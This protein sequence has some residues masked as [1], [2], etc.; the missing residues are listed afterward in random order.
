M[1]FIDKKNLVVVF[2]AIP[3]EDLNGKQAALGEEIGACAKSSKLF[4]FY[5][6]I[7][8]SMLQ[9]KLKDENAAILMILPDEK[10]TDY[11]V[12]LYAFKQSVIRSFRDAGIVIDNNDILFDF[13]SNQYIEELIDN[14]KRKAQ[15]S[16]A[17]QKANI[18]QKEID[19]YDYEE[20]A[21][22]FTPVNPLYSFNRVILPQDVI[23]KIERAVA[24][25]ENENKV[26][27]EWGLYEIQPH[28]SM[29][30][31]FFGPSGTGK[32]MAAEAVAEKLGKKILKVSYADVESKYHGEGPKMVKAI[33]L[34]AEKSGA[35]LFF[36]EA[37]SLLSK[38]LTNVS[39]GSEQ[40]INSMRSQL[41][42]CLE[43]FKGIV[44]F[45]TNLVIN[46]DKAFLTRLVSVAFPIPDE[47]TRI[48][49]WNNHIR[50]VDD[51]K[52][53]MLNIP[54]AP[55]VDTGE[56]A[57]KYEFVGREIRNAVVNACVNAA[58]AGKDMVSQADFMQACD[59]I[60]KEKDSI[61]NGKNLEMRKDSEKD[62]IRT[63]ILN[64]MK[65]EV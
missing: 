6:S 65:E 2:N 62:M 26:F 47:A 11:G 60:V 7:T 19:E 41:L 48:K 55:D 29:A 43:E 3:L 34:A 42:I 50:P 52:E 24:V 14:E 8:V 61:K 44:I 21:K 18:P 56:L 28:P 40:A 64:K 25:L 36:D 53:H 51:G 59:S 20:K 1:S 4:S 15:Q 17:T 49:I 12:Q 37:D 32:T 63:A 54:L 9:A 45:A 39:Q 22:Q 57:G 10:E 33:F 23:D 58:M 5:D 46:Y 30:L 27:K 38:R 31:S 35:V 13:R 16:T